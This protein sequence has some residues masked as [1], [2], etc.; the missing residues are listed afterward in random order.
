MEG[1]CSISTPLTTL[2]K[3][4][5]NFDKAEACE[6][7]FLELKDILT[8]ATV[9]TLPKFGLNYTIYCDASRVGLGC[10]LM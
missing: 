6:K 1:F 3:K 8:S 10:V 5:I 9:L 2:M 4:K 7:S